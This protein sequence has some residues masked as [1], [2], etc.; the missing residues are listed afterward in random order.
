VLNM[1]ESGARVGCAK[2]EHI[3][4]PTEVKE[5]YIASPENCKSVT[6]IETI[7]V[8]GKE[9]PPP[10]TIAPGKKIMDN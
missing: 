10:F 3:I 7:T 5:V 4:V 8:D 6:V 1:D 9:P 2:G